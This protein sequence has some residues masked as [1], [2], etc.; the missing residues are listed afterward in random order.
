M[1]QTQFESLLSDIA[2]DIAQMPVDA[3]LQTHLN[4][5]W[6][7][8]SNAFSQLKA[9]CKAGEQDGWLM[10]RE[11]GGIKFGRV[12]KPGTHT[13][14]FSVDVVRMKDIKGPHHVHPNGEIGAVMALSEG[15]K[16]DDFSEGW[17]VYEA[18][19]AHHPTVSNGEAYVLY[20]LPEG[21]IEFTQ[22]A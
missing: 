20:L 15:A 5:H 21:A 13:A 14:H 11:M 17:Y 6:G 4:Q 18:G 10:A 12:I 9:L 8:H 19:S 16:F 7:T 22:S 2:N 1:S 3:A